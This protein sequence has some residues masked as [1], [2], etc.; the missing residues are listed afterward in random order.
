MENERKAVFCKV[1]PGLNVKVCPHCRD[2][3]RK[4]IENRSMADKILDVIQD[5]KV[6]S[7]S[8]IVERA[9]L[10]KDEQIHDFQR[11][12]RL[13]RDRG[14]PVECLNNA[15]SLYK[16]LTKDEEESTRFWDRQAE[17]R[18]KT[19]EVLDLEAKVSELRLKLASL[20]AEN[21]FLSDYAK[22]QDAEIERLRHGLRDAA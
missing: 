15:E 22:E 6:H 21:K 12:I 14:L 3:E 20:E 16:L 2:L 11:A 8:E 9:D 1:N 5:N 13:L 18:T 19:K 17:K 10:M 7:L 4:R